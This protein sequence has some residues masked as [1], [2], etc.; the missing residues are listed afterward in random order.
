MLRE[1]MKPFIKL[2]ILLL[3]FVNLTAQARS[4][5]KEAPVSIEAD[6]LEMRQQ[7]NISIYRGHVKIQKGSL[8]ITG[9]MI[10]IKSKDGDLH[11]IKVKGKPATF[12][13][14]N[15]LGEAIKAESNEMDYLVKT[16]I[17]ELKDNALLVQNNNQFSSSHIIYNTLK[18][19]V[20]AGLNNKKS[21]KDKPRVKITFHP[22]TNTP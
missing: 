20:T 22:E 1:H 4:A 19:I 5:D 12:F 8:K 2:I 21:S 17:L 10:V 7:D 13:Q 6:Q 15:D 3:L 9:D 11:H 14:K 16:G 18:D